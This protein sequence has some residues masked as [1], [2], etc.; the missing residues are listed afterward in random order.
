MHPG[1]RR[2]LATQHPIRKRGKDF[3][4]GANNRMKPPLPT[5]EVIYGWV[6]HLDV[7][8]DKGPRGQCVPKD[9]NKHVPLWKK[10]YILIRSL[11]RI[12]YVLV[13]TPVMGV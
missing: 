5:G 2:I 10:V 1:H 12:I 3:K 11:T 9:S 4:G 8:F 7:V 13:S 6:K